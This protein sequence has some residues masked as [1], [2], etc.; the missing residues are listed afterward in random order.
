MTAFPISA[1]Y[2]FKAVLIK[3]KPL[4]NQIGCPV[5]IAQGLRDDTVH[6]KS[7]EYIFENVSSK[8]KH[9]K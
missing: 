5:F 9:I 1:L 4:L 7:A 2:N 3:T 6:K 8:E